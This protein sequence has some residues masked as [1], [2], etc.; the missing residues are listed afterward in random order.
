MLKALVP[1]NIVIPQLP[2]ISY[3]HHIIAMDHYEAA[4]ESEGFICIHLQEGTIHVRFCFAQTHRVREW[5]EIRFSPRN[6][7]LPSTSCITQLAIPRPK[8]RIKTGTRSLRNT[9]QR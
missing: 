8:P 5:S 7:C 9:A 1:T 4:E 6:G 2:Y 3:L